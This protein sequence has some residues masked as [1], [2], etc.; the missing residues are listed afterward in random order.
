MSLCLQGAT[1][2]VHRDGDENEADAVR[3]DVLI[4]NGVIERV[5]PGI[6]ASE[7]DEV[8]DCTDKIISPG[9]VDTHHH[10]WQSHLKGLHG[11][12][13]LLEYLP[14]G[15]MSGSFF[16]PDDVFFGQ[17]AGALEALDGG[18]TTILDHSHINYS[19]EHV[20][21]A[22]QA[23]IASG[24]R[25]VY[26]YCPTPRY[27]NLDEPGQFE[28]LPFM[29]NGEMD[30]FDALASAAPF[31]DGR[32]SLG[33]AF[34]GFFLPQAMLKPIFDRVHGAPSVNVITHHDNSHAMFNGKPSLLSSL[35]EMDL[36]DPQNKT[37]TVLSHSTKLGEEPMDDVL[38]H[39]MHVSITP[40]SELSMGMGQ[41]VPPAL[42]LLEHGE[43]APQMSIGVDCQTISES[44]IPGQLR[45]QLMAVRQHI[46]AQADARGQWYPSLTPGKFPS[47]LDAFNLATVGGARALG[48][49][50]QIGQ[51]KK[52]F[53]ADLLVWET[54]TPSMLACAQQDPFA[55]IV[56]HSH[57]SD[58]HGVLVDGIKRKWGGRLLPVDVAPAKAPIL[59]A[60]K[61]PVQGRIAWDRVADEIL[62]GRERIVAK[63][64]KFK[65]GQ[66]ND[67]VIDMWHLNKSVVS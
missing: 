6:D 8:L 44:F 66:Y 47:V 64:G 13:T 24:L 51:V 63:V 28:A 19:A 33:F 30:T 41:P 42:N 52:G 53:R 45:A 9:F 29:Q 16:E 5:E 55:A 65:R 67:T 11:D 4:R 26:G 14:S 10:L 49:G 21:A 54:K 38:R 2:L 48:M 27:K 59:S 23:S 3:A 50:K 20:Y 40:M 58:V 36:L 22:I 57:V 39:H 31:G 32:V 61:P 18:S 56:L 15:L 34:D 17:L 25:S 46:H 43:I 62:R 12:H 35:R 60:Y 1:V 7:A 37:F